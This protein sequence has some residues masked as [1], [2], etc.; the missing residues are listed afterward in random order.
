MCAAAQQEIMMNSIVT[1]N[2][3]ERGAALRLQD[4]LMEIRMMG[5]RAPLALWR[6][7]SRR[8]WKM[9]RAPME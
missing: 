2:V 8:Q 1:G 3:Y 6:Q 5:R 4:S 7:S 9:R